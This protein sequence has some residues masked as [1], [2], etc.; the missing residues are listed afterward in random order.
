MTLIKPVRGIKCNNKR[1]YDHQVRLLIP[2]IKF[3]QLDILFEEEFRN[4]PE[5][6]GIIRN[7][8]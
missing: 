7:I 8:E 5:K 1:K 4:G 3:F 6:F 2:E